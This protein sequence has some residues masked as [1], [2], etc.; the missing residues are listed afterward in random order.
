MVR[1]RLLSLW[2]YLRRRRPDVQSRVLLQLAFVS[3][4]ASRMRRSKVGIRIDIKRSKKQDVHTSSCEIL[5][6]FGRIWVI[7][8]DFSENVVFAAACNFHS[9]R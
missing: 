7:K 5:S 4:D 3:I 6:C 8:I 1:K 2:G 9:T